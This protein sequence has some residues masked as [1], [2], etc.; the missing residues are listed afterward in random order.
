MMDNSQEIA[1][2]IK[3]IAKEKKIN[4]GDL[5]SY[6]D[7]SK[8]A[9]SSMQSGGFMPRLENIVKIA[10]VLD[11]SVDYLLGRNIIETD[12]LIYARKKI[13]ELHEK[14]YSSNDAPQGVIE[15]IE[16]YFKVNYHTFRSWYNGYGD[17]FN[18]RLSLLADFYNITVDELLGRTTSRPA[19][20]LRLVAKDAISNEP[21]VE[22][23]LTTT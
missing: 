18:S 20:E 3:T 22:D 15:N 1:K 6:C 21:I 8:N 12:E 13:K 4:T 2:R 10:D 7:L 16:N 9:L 17:Y 11:V 23:E 14:T 5:L 19:P